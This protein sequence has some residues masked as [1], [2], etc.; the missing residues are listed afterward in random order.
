MC[1]R[2]GTEGLKSPA[3]AR[4]EHL[5]TQ[6]LL[7]V[8]LKYWE[9]VPKRNEVSRDGRIN[10]REMTT[11]L[12]GHTHVQ[13]TGVA[14]PLDVVKYCFPFDFCLCVCELELSAVPRSDAGHN[15][16]NRREVQPE[17]FSLQAGNIS[18]FTIHSRTAEVL[19]RI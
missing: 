2:F 8:I 4:D 19:C 7:T 12:R 3:I 6:L 10:S 17:L 18:G 5:F 1:W 14:S 16:F 11:Q 15:S 9:I 13:S